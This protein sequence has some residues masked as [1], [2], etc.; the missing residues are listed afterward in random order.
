MIAKIINFLLRKSNYSYIRRGK[1]KLFNFLSKVVPLPIKKLIVWVMLKIQQNLIFMLKRY[2]YFFYGDKNKYDVVLI[3]PKSDLDE[4]LVM[5]HSLLAI[6]QPLIE[7]NYKVKIIDQRIELDCWKNLKGILE[8]G[9]ICVGVTFFSGRQIKYACDL[10][11][12]I[13]STFSDISVVVGGTH[14]TV[15]SEQ[16]AAY[17]NLDIVVCGEGEETFLQ[18]VRTIEKKGDIADIRGV[19]FRKEKDIVKTEA[20]E[21]VCLSKYV[22]VPLFLLH[23]YL[24]H[25]F[26]GGVFTSRGCPK[27]CSY[28]VIPLL[29]PKWRTLEPELAVERIKA[30]MSI[31]A[32][33]IYFFDDNFFASK[34]RVEELLNIFEREKLNIEWWVECRIDDLLNMEESFL[35]KLRKEGLRKVFLGAESG[36]DRILQLVNKDLTVE[37]TIKVNLL[38]K[39][40]DI[41]PEYTF[42]IGFPT[43]TKEEREKTFSLIKKLKEDNPEALFWK[44]NQYTAYPGTKLSELAVKE[45]FAP[46][47]TL[48]EWADLSFYRREYDL[49]SYD[50]CLD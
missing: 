43:E 35:T 36:S 37:M 18:V 42:M 21:P 11:D 20:A 39:K 14:A 26:L 33:L 22:S 27:K 48:R 47:K 45:G 19:C 46:P 24:C 44:L 49:V 30:L 32:R 2:S 50:R 7:S 40:F 8:Q 6:A 12:K 28:C 17:K 10:M 38:L 13:K 25:Y 3:Y 1:P 16:T 4:S 23:S 15:L 29:S 41:V 31:G 5:P 34:K 9:V